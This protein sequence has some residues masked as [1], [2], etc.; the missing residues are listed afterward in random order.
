MRTLLLMYFLVLGIAPAVEH[1]AP[2][3]Y[4]SDAGPQPAQ[5]LPAGLVTVLEAPTGRIF[6]GQSWIVHYV[7]RNRGT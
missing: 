4:A 2:E 5:P 7:V 1:R 6:L 3:G